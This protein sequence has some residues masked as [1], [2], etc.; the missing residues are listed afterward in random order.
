MKYMKYKVRGEDGIDYIIM[1][2][3]VKLGG[4]DTIV[5][6]TIVYNSK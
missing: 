3:K 1:Q 4:Q 2:P 6:N 5:H